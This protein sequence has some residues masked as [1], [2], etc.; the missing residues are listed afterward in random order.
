MNLR[1]SKTCLVLET[2]L[3]VSGFVYRF[4]TRAVY[5]GWLFYWTS[6]NAK[7]KAVKET[8]YL[9]RLVMVRREIVGFKALRLIQS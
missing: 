8:D 5:T 2:S 7:R 1:R 3:I 9:T 4:L 6:A